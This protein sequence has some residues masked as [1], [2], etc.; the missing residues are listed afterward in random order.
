MSRTGCQG[1][2]NNNNSEIALVNENEVIPP[3]YEDPEQLFRARNRVNNAMR[4]HQNQR[5]HVAQNARNDAGVR[6]LPPPQPAPPIHRRPED[7]EEY[8]YEPTMNELSA[9]HFLNQLWCI[10]E[11]PKLAEI[12]IKTAVVHH[13]P[14]FSGRQGESATKHL[15]SFHGICQTLQPYGVLVEDFN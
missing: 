2:D 10:D 15:Q 8:Y 3:F 13:L 7:D 9:P 1:G 11:G 4:A 12:E 6:Q 14:K 5:V